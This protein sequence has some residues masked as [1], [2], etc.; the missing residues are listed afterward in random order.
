MIA[1]N[2]FTY[3]MAVF[4]Y[5][6]VGYYQN[7]KYVNLVVFLCHFAGFHAT[8]SALK[9]SQYFEIILYL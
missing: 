9:T 1:G 4:L 5:L 2:I 7:N 8:P 3:K 6:G